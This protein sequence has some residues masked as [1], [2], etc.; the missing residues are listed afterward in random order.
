M[1]LDLNGNAGIVAKILGAV[2]GRA[3][4]TNKQFV[5][6]GLSYIDAGWTYDNLAGLALSAAGA[7][8]PDQVVT[9]LWTNVIG[10]APT[11][12]NKAPFIGMLQGGTTPGALAHMAADTEFNTLNINLVGLMQTGIGFIG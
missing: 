1:A 6:I 7:S 5:G 8:S 4:V 12:S 2:F 9:L 11:E 10:S 3:A